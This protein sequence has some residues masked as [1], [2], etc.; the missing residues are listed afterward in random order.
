MDILIFPLILSLPFITPIITFVLARIT[1]KK[2][3]QELILSKNSDRF[4]QSKKIALKFKIAIII[5]FSTPLLFLI[6][7]IINPPYNDGAQG[8]LFFMFVP[9]TLFMLIP[10]IA[11]T[12]GYNYLF[13]T[14]SNKKAFFILAIPFIPTFFLGFLAVIKAVQ[15]DWAMVNGNVA[16]FIILPSILF[17]GI[18]TIC[19]FFFKKTQQ[20][21]K[22]QKLAKDN[23]WTILLF[24]LFIYWFSES[25]LSFP[26]PLKFLRGGRHRNQ[27]KKTT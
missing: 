10:A 18:M 16:A 19:L 23:R 26:F 14:T 22:Q 25:H 3:R 2:E 11:G 1:T 12:H 20:H 21:S 6:P 24:M 27:N 9:S 4:T 17:L 7:S 8:A 5:Y 15:G 13:Y